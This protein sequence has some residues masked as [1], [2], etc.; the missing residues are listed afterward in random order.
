MIR[1][2]YRFKSVGHTRENMAN[3]GYR[4]NGPMAPDACVLGYQGYNELQHLTIIIKKCHG[5]CWSVVQH[6]RQTIIIQFE[7]VL[8]VLYAKLLAHSIKVNAVGSR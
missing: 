7:T 3:G 1:A 6:N 5:G 2:N 8:V 4:H